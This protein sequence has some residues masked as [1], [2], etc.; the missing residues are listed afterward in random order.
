VLEAN[1][2]GGWFNKDGQVDG[3]EDWEGLDT[4]LSELA[5]ASIST[6]EKRLTFTLVVVKCHNNERFMP[7]VRKWLPKLLPRF[8]ELG[9]LH[10][11]YMRGGC[12][13]AVDDGCLHH[14]KPDCLREGS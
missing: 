1:Y 2:V 12:C 11:H 6:R 7:A 8:S 3:E 10:V 4:V 14:D 13:R 9:L 5:E